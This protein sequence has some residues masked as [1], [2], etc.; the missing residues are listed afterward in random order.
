MDP[1]A[2]PHAVSES[3]HTGVSEGRLQAAD[4]L[5]R[6]EAE[7]GGA[8]AEREDAAA[9]YQGAVELLE[10]AWSVFTECRVMRDGLL[11]ACQEIERTMDAVE[12]RL[13]DEA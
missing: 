4:P 8:G 2:A 5:A 12:R 3:S 6:L 1:R 13:G 11:E 7:L 10:D 9:L